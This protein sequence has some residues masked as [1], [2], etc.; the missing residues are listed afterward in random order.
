MEL[1]PCPFCG[2]EKLDYSEKRVYCDS[3]TNV[4]YHAAIYCR[5][6][7][8]YGR[9]VLSEKAWCRDYTAQQALL[10]GLREKAIEAWN[11]RVDNGT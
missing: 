1:K 3:S 5:K 6:C 11:R 9:R 4:Y 2:G 7:H 10:N 8:A